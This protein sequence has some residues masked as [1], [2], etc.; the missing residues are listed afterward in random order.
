[1]RVLTDAVSLDVTLAYRRVTAAR[2]MIDLARPAVAEAV[3]NLRLMRE[4]YRNGDAM[5]TDIVDAQ[6]ALTRAR[7]AAFVG[8]T[9]AYQIGRPGWTTRWVTGRVACWRPRSSRQPTCRRHGSCPRRCRRLDSPSRG[10][11]EVGISHRRGEPRT[12]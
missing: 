9:Y 12:K 8:L 5:P 3:E 2:Q 11:Q 7:C 4:R 10:R 6:T 1:M